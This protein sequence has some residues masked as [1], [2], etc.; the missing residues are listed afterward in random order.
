MASLNDILT[1]S[2]SEGSG[3]NLAKNTNKT[4]HWSTFYKQ[5]KRPFVTPEKRKHYD[6]L[7][8]E[9]KSKL[10]AIDGWYS[11]AT[12][13]G[14][15]RN[16]KNLLDRDLIT[17]DID[18]P[19]DS[20]IELI[21][22]G[23]LGVS[24]FTGLWHSSRSHTPKSPRVRGIFPMTRKVSTDEYTAIV[25]YF[26][27]LI[28]PEMK[29]VDPVSYRPA[30]MMFKP[31]CSVDDVPHYFFMLQDEKPVDPDVLLE[32]I[33]AR[34]GDWRDLNLLP[35]HPDETDHRKRA[36]KAEDP[37]EK[38]GPVGD[39]CRAFPDIEVA[40]ERF[41]PEVYT[42]GDNGPDGN[43]RYTY[44]GGSAANGA[45]IYEHKFLYSW[46][47][48]DPVNDML[49]NAFD[50]IR[51]HLFGDQD[52]KED[53]AYPKMSDRPSY[54]AMIDMVKG[55]PEYQ[56]QVKQR[57]FSATMAFAEVEE[58]E[59]TAEDESDGQEGSAESGDD[60]DVEPDAD[61]ADGG[62]GGDD[63]GPRSASGKSTRDSKR[64]SWESAFDGIDPD[65][66][67]AFEEAVGS[68]PGKQKDTSPKARKKRAFP[69]PPKNWF[70]KR[71]ESTENGELKST[72]AN[73]QNIIQWDARF[74]GKIGFNEFTQR[75]CLIGTIDPGFKG[76]P[77][78]I[79]KDPHN[80]DPWQ[81][82]F[83]GMIHYVL[84]AARGDE[85]NGYGMKVAI[86]DIQIAINSVAR[87][88][89]Y[90]PIRDDLEGA[91]W[92]GKPR[93]E[94][95][96]IDY[97]GEPDT[98]YAREVAKMFLTAAVYRVMTP[99]QKWDNVII[100][101]G[102]Q[103]C[104]KSTFVRELF[105]PAYFGE[106]HADL[107]K[108]KEVAEQIGGIWGCELPELVSL[109]KTEVNALKSWTRSRKDDCR[110]AYMKHVSILPRQLVA[111]GTTND[112]TPLKDPTGNRVFLM[113]K[114]HV[115]RINTDRLAA[116]REQILAEA[117]HWYR[118][119][120]KLE[121]TDDLTLDFTSAEALEEART[122]QDGAR[123][124]SPAERLDADILDWLDQPVRL[125][126][127]RRAMGLP[128]DQFSETDDS[129]VM[130]VRNTFRE[131]DLREQFLKQDRFSWNFQADGILYQVL[132]KLPGWQKQG[133]KHTRFGT[134]RTG[135]RG[136]W[137]DREGAWGEDIKKGYSIVTYDDDDDD[138]DFD[139][140]QYV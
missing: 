100:I 19:M 46:H 62:A 124:Q 117:M 8:V 42:L 12:F 98:P 87:I 101:Q 127:L 53:D 119:A 59:Y 107:S 85:S 72:L 102:P 95:L 80:G 48:T 75:P 139:P 67:A 36:D 55:L 15:W 122:R 30:Q 126:D 110:M 93:G 140:H 43:T 92:D 41:L 132:Q 16:K 47:G 78:L 114:V 64:A 52:K 13:S 81:D 40:M 56:E 111:V 129:D 97:L 137:F 88:N 121:P 118:E 108:P 77:K 106:L 130:V 94:R 50:L 83:D 68:G 135:L 136:I 26:G 131:K 60:A 57:K 89:S 82:H 65:Y 39:F 51:I 4:G 58:D 32:E 17:I 123:V 105:S 86:S 138:D 25:R 1:V 99:G 7:S 3:N 71:L 66:E 61:D 5:F 34:F 45:V 24:Q 29:S 79:C 23:L 54:K 44:T 120:R 10:K 116:E 11:G 115:D 134:R 6:K 90:H 70:V 73:I 103:G 109:N 49:V 76:I 112:M 9:E 35:K 37:L 22:Q 27:F 125:I 31:T 33:E 2:W 21:E 96:F 84:E 113:L 128:I 18:Y 28:D 104:R 91:T 63:A 20:L 38:L 74:W 14:K 133:G 69:P